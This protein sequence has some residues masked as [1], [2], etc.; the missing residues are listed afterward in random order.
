[1]AH[2]YHEPDFGFGSYGN[3]RTDDFHMDIDAEIKFT[4][5]GTTDGGLAITAV[6]E[7][8][9]DSGG[10][11]SREPSDRSRAVL[12]PLTLGEEGQFGQHARK[13]GHRRRLWRR[14]LLRRQLLHPGQA[15]A[16]RFPTAI[17]L[18]IRYSTPAIGGF[19]AGISFQ[20]EDRCGERDQPSLTTAT[21]LRLARI[22]SGDFAGTSLTLSAGHATVKPAGTA[23]P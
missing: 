15:A 2:L 7:F 6:M 13:Q 23:I 8:D 14:R 3:R 19:Q 18:G 17:D 10:G 21:R 20:P 4:A 22:S 5:T 9:A 1:M 11:V 12:A 16:Q